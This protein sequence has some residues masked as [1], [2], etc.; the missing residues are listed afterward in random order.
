MEWIHRNRFL[1]VS[2]KKIDEHLLD[3]GGQRGHPHRATKAE[4][5]MGGDTSEATSR[6]GSK[7]CPAYEKRPFGK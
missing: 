1:Q 6:G 4:Y 5:T 3:G 2:R 7:H